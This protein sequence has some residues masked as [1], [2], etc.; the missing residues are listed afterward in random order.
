LPGDA[1]TATNFPSEVTFA[2]ANGPPAPLAK[3]DPATGLRAPFA[4]TVNTVMFSDDPFATIR[5]LS[6]G[7]VVNDIPLKPAT[8]PVAKGEPGTDVRTPVSGSTENALTV[9]LP[10]LPANK[11]FFTT[12]VV[13][14]LEAKTLPPP[15]FP[16]VAKGEPGTVLRSVSRRGKRRHGVGSA[17]I[18]G[19]NEGTLRHHAQSAETQQKNQM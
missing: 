11:K 8:P 7:V 4:A 2:L 14:R 5:N 9:S 1:D 13:I 17:I 10:P 18:V 19:V 3:G 6:S 16:P 12:A 15:P